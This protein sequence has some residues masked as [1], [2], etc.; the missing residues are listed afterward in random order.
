LLTQAQLMKS[1]TL[2]TLAARLGERSY[3][4]P[5]GTTGGH[6]RAI[7]LETAINI[8]HEYLASPVEASK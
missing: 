4:S 8:I 3:Y 7:R 6:L 5:D 2:Q 1:E